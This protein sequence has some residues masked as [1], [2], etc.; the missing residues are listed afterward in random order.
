MF[1]PARA[2]TRGR[3]GVNRYAF[4]QESLPLKLPG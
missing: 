1:R 3:T 2:L 4:D